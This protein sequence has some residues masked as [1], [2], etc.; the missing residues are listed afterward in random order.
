MKDILT[1]IFMVLV[2]ALMFAMQVERSKA[3]A[4][5]EAQGG[6]YIR[7]YQGSDVCWVD[8]RPAWTPW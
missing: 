7:A 5:C 8:G 4:R 3:Q 2:I 6:I 1:A